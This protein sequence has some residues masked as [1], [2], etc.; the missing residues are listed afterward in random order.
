MSEKLHEDDPEDDKSCCDDDDAI[1]ANKFTKLPDKYFGIQDIFGGLEFDEKP[2][3]FHENYSLITET[4]C[5]IGYVPQ[6]VPTPHLK[7]SP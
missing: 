1:I 2:L 7:T 4:D 5:Q 3:W 6:T